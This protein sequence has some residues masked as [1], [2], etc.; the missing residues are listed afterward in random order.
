M[1]VLRNWLQSNILLAS[2]GAGLVLI[3]GFSI[4]HWG[5]GMPAGQGSGV[6]NGDAANIVH[7]QPLI[8]GYNLIP[9]RQ[10][11]L[12]FDAERVLPHL[13]LPQTSF[14]IGQ[15]V[16]DA[17]VEVMFTVHNTGQGLLRIE[18]IYTT[19]ACLVA[20]LTASVIP[21]GKVALLRVRFDPSVIDVTAEGALGVRYG[22]FIESNDPHWSQA[23][24]W[25]EAELVSDAF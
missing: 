20:H 11:S 1:R 16:G 2:I 8:G 21:S 7:D 10:Q 18:H 25:I 15:L 17:A 24:L 23:S 22:V 4:W 19:C 9:V 6:N 3:A 12:S 13:H 5:S 14:D